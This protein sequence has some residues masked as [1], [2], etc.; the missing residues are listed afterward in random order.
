MI[1]LGQLNLP[2]FQDSQM[3]YEVGCYYYKLFVSNK[4]QF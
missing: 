2:K 3:S 1:G 4:S